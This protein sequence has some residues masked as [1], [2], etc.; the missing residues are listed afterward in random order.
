LDE[1]VLADIA[2]NDE[3]PSVRR[4]AIDNISDENVLTDIAKNAGD[5]SVRI[6]AIGKISD[7]DVLVDI[8]KS[9][10]DPIIHKYLKNSNMI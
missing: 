2:K 9:T 1:N 6:G 10:E 5:L 8:V 3:D 4:A 7:E